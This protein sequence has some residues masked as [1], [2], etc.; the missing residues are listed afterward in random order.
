LRGRKKD[1][2]AYVMDIGYAHL[3]LLL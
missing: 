2:T 1:Q 3:C